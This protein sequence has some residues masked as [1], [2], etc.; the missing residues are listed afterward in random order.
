MKLTDSDSVFLEI[1][2]NGNGLP[3]GFEIN[4]SNSMGMRL[5]VGLAK[6]IDGVLDIKNDNGVTIDILFKRER[7]LK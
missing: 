5:I 2:D 7:I 1:K 3:E 4:K 6:Q